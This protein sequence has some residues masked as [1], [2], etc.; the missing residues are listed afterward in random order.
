[1]Q[2]RPAANGEAMI[3]TTHAIL[4]ATAPAA[5]ITAGIILVAGGLIV[6]LLRRKSIVLAFF[7]RRVEGGDALVAPFVVDQYLHTLVPVLY[8]VVLYAAC[9][10]IALTP[11][12]RHALNLAEGAIIVFAVFR[13]LVAGVVFLIDRYVAVREGE[14][15]GSSRSIRAL[16]PVVQ[17]TLWGIGLVFLLE[18]FGFRVEAIVTGLGIGGVAVALA[19]QSLLKDVFGYVAIVLDRPFEIG[20]VIQTDT[21]IGSVEVIGLKTTHIRSLGGEQIVFSNSDL[22]AA[23]IRNWKRMT[24]RRVVFDFAV[25][26]KTPADQVSEIPA[27]VQATI[28]ALP[29]TRFDRAHFASFADTGLTFEVVYYVRSPDYNVYMDRQQ[30]INLA[31]KAELDRRAISF[32]TP[33]QTL[34]VHTP[35]GEVGA[36]SSG[37]TADAVGAITGA[38]IATRG[39][40]GTGRAPAARE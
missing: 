25:A 31:L 2:T 20:D 5:W 10:S 4:N 1:V 16:V 23:R 34:V 30:S 36:G 12:L 35:D 40:A 18:N 14:R 27:F 24:E 39:A 7:R 9:A 8:A 37:G 3:E 13:L 21:F 33:T 29:D 11:G 26:A 22:T 38:A 17:V 6:T 32:A 15:A 28:E 19:A